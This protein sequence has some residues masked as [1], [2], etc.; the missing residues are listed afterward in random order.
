MRFSAPEKRLQQ[1][2]DQNTPRSKQLAFAQID[3]LYLNVLL[4]A[5]QDDESN[6][7]NDDLCIRLHVLIGAV[8]LLRLPLDVAALAELLEVS[9]G[10]LDRDVRALSAVLL[11]TPT[12][13]TENRASYTVQIFHPSF[14]D[15]L[16]DRCIDVRFSIHAASQHEKL[17]AHC[18]NQ[19]NHNLTYDICKI[20]DPTLANHEVDNLPL[21]TRLLSHVS[22]ALRY[23]CTFWPTHIRYSHPC[24]PTSALLCALREFVQNHILHWIELLS[25]VGLVKDAVR[26]LLDVMNWCQVSL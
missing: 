17:A 15:F 4:A 24:Q 7:I 21:S 26:W 16:L 12:T 11:T 18:L 3:S 22:S 20:L 14:Q 25:L 1:I 23:A 5:A 13:S 19:L 6:H 2:H 9:V 10:E 8:I